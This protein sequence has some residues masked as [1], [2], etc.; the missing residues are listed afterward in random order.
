MASPTVSLEAL[1]THLLIGVHEDRKFISFDI[2]GGF[3]QSDMAEDKLVLMKFKGQFADM[4]V[5]VNPEYKGLIR[6]EKTKSGKSIQVLYLKVIRAIYGCIE[7]ALQWYKL[8]TEV[9]QKK[10]FK[11]NPYDKC[12]ANKMING[13]QCSVAWHVDDCMASHKEQHVLEYL[14]KI[15]IKHFGEMD[16]KTGDEHEFL[17]M[18]IIFNRRNRTVNIGM[19]TAVE[20][21][22]DDFEKESG[23]IRGAQVTTPSNHSL[24]RVDEMSV[25]LDSNKSAIFHSTTAKLLYLMK[26]VRPDL[27]TSVSFL[28]KRVSKSTDEDWDKLKRVLN[29]VKR[30]KSDERTIGA[31]TLSQIWNFIDA[32][33]AVH[34]NMRSHTGGLMSMGLGLIHGKSCSQTMN[35]KSST[36]SE[37]VGVSEYLPYNVWF[38]NFMEEQG[39]QIKE[40]ILYQDNKS[41]ILMEI[42]GRNSCTGNSRHINIRYFWVKDRVDKG[43]IKIR[44]LPTHLMLADFFTK[45]LMGKLFETMREYIMGWK[46][47]EDLILQFDEDRIKEDVEI[48]TC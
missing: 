8:F 11:L 45:P 3:L 39:Y 9:L 12:I 18:T 15:M 26:R 23:E 42:N 4:M 44:Y 48:R 37:L 33:H 47:I 40:N 22:I 17:G 2:P 20:K 7:A 31:K 6:Y 36:E 32:S 28:M 10:G 19:N 25:E 41:A 21:I 5:T 30:T 14:G 35:T 38:C 1:V 13:N 27:E 24:F 46:P 16:I 43:K 29:Y 34:E